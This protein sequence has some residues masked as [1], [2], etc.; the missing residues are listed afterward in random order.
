LHSNKK[1][2]GLAQ[3]GDNTGA[4]GRKGQSPN[5][6]QG[7]ENKIMKAAGLVQLGTHTS[8]TGRMN[9]S[10]EI[11][12]KPVLELAWKLFGDENAIAGCVENSVL[13]DVSYDGVQMSLRMN[14]FDDATKRMGEEAQWFGYDLDTLSDVVDGSHEMLNMLDI[15]GNYG[16]VT[17][18]A[19]KKYAKTL[20][21]IAVEPIPETFFFLVWNLYI[22]EVPVLNEAAM[23]DEKDAPGVLALNSGSGDVAGQELNFCAYPWSSMNSKVCDCK[24]S[25]DNCHVVPSITVDRLASMFASDPIAMVKMDCEGCEFKSLP[26]LGKKHL[27]KRV[28]RLAGELHMPDQSLEELA[29]RWDN[30]RLVSKCQQGKKGKDD[31]ECG[32]KLAC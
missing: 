15:G 5:L 3:K 6:Q 21:V 14:K 17:I 18:A 8:N 24:P 30:G 28:R 23:K 13:V 22:N 29:C 4:S 16:V 1:G 12:P 26:A 25:Q 19:M 2:D 7:G 20:R 10:L 31:V 27:A 9:P 11:L 32:V